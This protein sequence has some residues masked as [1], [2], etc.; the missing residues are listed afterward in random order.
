MAV[1]VVVQEGVGVVFI[2]QKDKS[3]ALPL[4]SLVF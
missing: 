3:T 4:R 1:V 2:V